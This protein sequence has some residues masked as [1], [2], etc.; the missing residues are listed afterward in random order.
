MISLSD[1]TWHPSISTDSLPIPYFWTQIQVRVPL[2]TACM[3]ISVLSTMRLRAGSVLAVQN[4]E[5]SGTVAK[6][7]EIEFNA[8]EGSLSIMSKGVSSSVCWE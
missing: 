1:F 5:A 7:Q 3:S 2:N 8:L 6:D 4:M